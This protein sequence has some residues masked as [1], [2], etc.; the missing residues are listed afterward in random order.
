MAD[1]LP[2]SVRSLIV[3][4][5]TMHDSEVTYYHGSPTPLEIG[6]ELVPG[7]VGGTEAD[8]QRLAVWATTTGPG[9]AWKWGKRTILYQSEEPRAWVY[10]LVLTDVK[11]DTNGL[12]TDPGSVM[13]EAGRVVREVGCFLSEAEAD[14][15]VDCA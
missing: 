5:S 7:I 12:R 1:A 11:P 2:R 3:A 14:A 4:G 6:I 9:M 10:E 8:P 13:A 15:A